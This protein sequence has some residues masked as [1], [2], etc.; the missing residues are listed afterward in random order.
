MIGITGGSGVIYAIRLLEFLSQLGNLETHL[1][2]SSAGAITIKTETSYTLHDVEKLATKTYRIGDIAASISSGSFK[3]ESM[4][5][6]P[7]SMHTLGAIASGVSENLILRAAEVT[8]KENRKLVLVPR[9][10][11]LTLIHLENMAKVARAGAIVL[12]AM[13][14][15]YEKPKN[16][17]D[18]VNHLVGKVLD[19]LEV[20]NEIFKRWPGI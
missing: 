16:I 14:A 15:F 5:I 12:P 7:C 8:M 1:V 20:E 13:P 4:V 19:I 6:I 18:I 3:F 9:E 10:T 17:D 11:P 2:T